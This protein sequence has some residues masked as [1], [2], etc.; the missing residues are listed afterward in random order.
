M[1]AGYLP[2]ADTPGAAR[3]SASCGYAALSRFWPSLARLVKNV[4]FGL[5]VC[6]LSCDTHVQRSQ[7]DDR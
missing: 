2:R 3:L 7:G 6:F 1:G 4:A 5:E